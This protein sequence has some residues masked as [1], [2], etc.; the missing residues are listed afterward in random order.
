MPRSGRQHFL[1]SAVWIALWGAFSARAVPAVAKIDNLDVSTDFDPGTHRCNATL[2]NVGDKVIVA[3]AWET[4]VIRSDGETLGP[5]LQVYDGRYAYADQAILPDVGKAHHQ[6]LLPG[7]SKELTTS[8][9]SDAVSCNIEVTAVVYEDRTAEGDERAIDIIFSDRAA[10]A[11]RLSQ[12]ADALKTYP[13]STDEAKAIVQKLSELNWAGAI[14]LQQLFSNGGFQLSKEG[15][16]AN[17]EKWKAASV[18]VAEETKALEQQAR[19]V[20]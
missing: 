9:D 4:T 6:L 5:L 19:R 13:A 15:L 14:S 12:A 8:V 1:V 16:P 2:T 17:P 3:R 11:K 18:I 7:K 10:A 20:K